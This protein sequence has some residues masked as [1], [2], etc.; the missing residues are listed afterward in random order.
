MRVTWLCSQRADPLCTKR[1]LST[2]L[3]V[4]KLVGKGVL[5]MI[6]IKHVFASTLVLAACGSD[7][8][9]PGAGDSA[10]GGTNTLLVD[11]RA[12]AEP[13]FANAKLE[14]DFETE[15]SVRVLLN[16]ADV[17]TGAVTVTSRFGEVALTFDSGEN[18]WRGTMANYDEVYELNIISGSDEV[19]G[20]IVDGPDIH[21]VKEPLAGATLDSTI[22]NPFLWDRDDQADIATFDAEEIDRITVADVGS[23]MMGIGVLKAEQDQARTN[24]LELTRTNHVAPAGAVGGS[25]F[26]VTVEN[27]IEV[28]VA[29]N[30]AL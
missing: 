20:V 27:Y 9:D 16:G 13:R 5:S 1:R 26:A 15:M 6:H 18:R 24:T 28:V 4:E 30:P 10:G 19:R 7:P 2:V 12:R 22:Q 29:P 3:L 21:T 17:T 11:G 25:D 23:Y 8:L 14:T